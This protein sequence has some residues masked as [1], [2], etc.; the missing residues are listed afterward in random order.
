[1]ASR[2]GAR[3]KETRKRSA[4]EFPSEEQQEEISK[5]CTPGEE[6]AE[7]LVFETNIDQANVPLKVLANVRTVVYPLR[8]DHVGSPLYRRILCTWG[9]PAAFRGGLRAYRHWTDVDV[10]QH[11]RYVSG[12]VEKTVMKVGEFDWEKSF[13]PEQIEMFKTTDFY[14]DTEY[15]RP[16]L[17]DIREKWKSNQIQFPTCATDEGNVKY[18]QILLHRGLTLDLRKQL[19]EQGLNNKAIDRHLLH[20]TMFFKGTSIPVQKPKQK[21]L[22]P[23]TLT[24]QQFPRRATGAALSDED[25]ENTER[26]TTI[27]FS[28]EWK[29]QEERGLNKAKLSVKDMKRIE[30]S[31]METEDVTG[32]PTQGTSGVHL[33]K[34]L[35]LELSHVDAGP[36]RVQPEFVGP[37][38]VNELELF[39]RNRLRTV[40]LAMRHAKE[41]K[42][43]KE[44][45]ALIEQLDHVRLNLHNA[46]SPDFVEPELS[47]IDTDLFL[48]LAD[49]VVTY[50]SLVALLANIVDQQGMHRAIVQAREYSHFIEHRNDEV[51]DELRGEIQ[52]FMMTNHDLFDNLDVNPNIGTQG[53]PGDWKIKKEILEHA[54]DTKYTERE[55]GIVTEVDPPSCEYESLATY[56]RKHSKEELIEA[57]ELISSKMDE[58][59]QA[60]DADHVEDLGVL[61]AKPRGVSKHVGTG[62]GDDDD[63]GKEDDDVDDDDDDENTLDYLETQNDDDDEL[64]HMDDNNST[65]LKIDQVISMGTTNEDEPMD[66]DPDNSIAPP[67]HH[68]DVLEKDMIV[69]SSQ[70]PQS[71]VTTEQQEKVSEIDPNKVDVTPATPLK[72]KEV[73]ITPE[74]TPVEKVT[75]KPLPPPPG[76][77]PEPPGPGP[78]PS[79]IIPEPEPPGPEPKPSE[80][81]PEPEPPVPKP[82]SLEITPEPQQPIRSEPKTAEPDPNLKDPSQEIIES[83]EKEDPQEGLF[84][85]KFQRPPLKAKPL[86]KTPKQTARKST[87][88]RPVSDNRSKRVDKPSKSGKKSKITGS[89]KRSKPELGETDDTPVKKQKKRKVRK[90]SSSSEE[91]ESEEVDVLPKENPTRFSD[92]LAGKE[93]EE[94]EL[95][96]PTPKKKKVT[97]TRE[98]TVFY[99]RSDRWTAQVFVKRPHPKPT[100]AQKYIMEYDAADVELKSIAVQ[101]TEPRRAKKVDPTPFVLYGN[102][103]PKKGEFGK[104]PHFE[105]HRIIK[106]PV[107]REN[108]GGSGKRT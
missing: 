74:L 12:L 56:Y 18:R 41:E 87:G 29:M 61:K 16:S 17:K 1:M 31:A 8:W 77:E 51:T 97:T 89:P 44:L 20:M 50:E 7:G 82:K 68:V 55:I 35:R 62:T 101:V 37:V 92:R 71:L 69:T 43:D 86:M 88:G 26:P 85:G 54:M 30:Q 3:P 25:E 95:P 79:E 45:E 70:N 75:S 103:P 63:L 107:G 94:L 39:E 36:R 81:I 24:Y 5:F 48:S 11:L 59:D 66:I 47:E 53:L 42:D 99:G 14:Q 15:D 64:V 104:G 100:L 2:G 10:A 34:D 13:T 83:E 21:G 52:A 84:P 67:I 98:G 72:E 73:D 108:Y 102:L 32:E 78:K 65:G 76:P 105:I 93:A 80:I 38:E 27:D 33:D 9:M 60:Y 91:E 40:Y 23:T 46:I 4:E 22:K 49:F 28:Q 96:K 19:K 57:Q 6:P 90:L 58:I 106:G